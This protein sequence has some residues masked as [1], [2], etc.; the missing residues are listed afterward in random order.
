MLM[1][2][3][4]NVEIVLTIAKSVLRVITEISSVIGSC[5]TA[6]NLDFIS[7][8]I[9]DI[10]RNLRR[11][12]IV[13]D[14]DRPNNKM[15][16]NADKDENIRDWVPNINTKMHVKLSKKNANPKNTPNTILVRWESAIKK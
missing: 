10:E 16:K 15:N 3:T 12:N 4:K 6:L 7:E 2:I 13:I 1:K 5:S 8:K 11:N 9:P 14:N